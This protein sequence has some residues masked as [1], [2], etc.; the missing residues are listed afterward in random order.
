MKH[1]LGRAI[2]SYTADRVERE[3]TSRQ[4]ASFWVLPLEPEPGE[5][6]IVL[7]RPDDAPG[8]RQD[9]DPTPGQRINHR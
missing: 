9:R 7:G 6:E 1:L 4:L 5:G 2:S 3:A 8:P